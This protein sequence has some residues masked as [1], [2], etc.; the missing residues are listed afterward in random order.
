[1]DAALA[2]ERFLPDIQLA[3]PRG[4]V[5]LRGA[6]GQTTILVSVHSAGCAGCRRYLAELASSAAEFAAWDGRLLIAVPGPE[7]GTEALQLP[8]GTV[9]ADQGQRISSPGEAGVIVADRYGQIYEVCRTGAGHEFP[10][11]R[12]LEEWLKFLGTLCPE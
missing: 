3:S 10:P 6:A 5:A 8:F 2:V 12:Q 9:L 4:A 7:T 1:M 11:P